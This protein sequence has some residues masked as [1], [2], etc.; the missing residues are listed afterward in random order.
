MG[1]GVGDHR[2]YSHYSFW[3]LW[4]Y[5]GVA[6]VICLECK[7]Q[8]LKSKVYPGGS[9][10][11]LMYCQP[12]YDE[13]GNYHHHDYNT[14]TTEYSCSKGHKWVEHRGGSCWCGWSA[15]GGL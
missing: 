11:T 14:T 3:Y 5:K 9:T 4:G 13:E 10:T 7:K 12:F 15:D 8:G 1:L 6:E 2:Y